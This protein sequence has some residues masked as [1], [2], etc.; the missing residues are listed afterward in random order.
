[1]QDVGVQHREATYDADEQDAMPQREPEELRLI[2]GRHASGRGSYG[3]RLQTDHLT[4][5]AAH[6]IGSGNEHRIEA[7]AGCGDHLQIAKQCVG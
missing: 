4:H 5:N 6:R 3:D 2:L 7:Q 1:M